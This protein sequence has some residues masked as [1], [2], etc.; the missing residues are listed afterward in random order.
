MHAH[1][2]SLTPPGAGAA[3]PAA[4]LCGAAVPAAGMPIFE[5]IAIDSIAVANSPLS[6]EPEGSVVLG[7]VPFELPDAG[8]NNIWSSDAFFASL[9]VRNTVDV[10]LTGVDAVHA[11]VNVGFERSS[12]PVGQIRFQGSEGAEFVFDFE[13]RVN[14]RDWLSGAPLS[15][16][17]STEVFRDPD[18]R[19]LIDSLRIDLPDEFLSQ[20][21]LFVQLLDVTGSDR[22][23]VIL[24]NGITAELVPEPS[25]A[26]LL[27]LTGLALLRR[28]VGRGGPAHA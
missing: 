21:L 27:G 22:A 1:L 4:L 2:R 8:G 19:G 14:V 25:A 6:A 12:L 11:L 23:N 28:R 9:P 10:G 17:D 13:A 7:G 5:T 20:E 16:P 18:G 15:N 3:W 26:A 24:F